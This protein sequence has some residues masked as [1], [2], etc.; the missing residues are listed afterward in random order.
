M[1]FALEA[2]VL[3]EVARQWIRKAAVAPE[4]FAGDWPCRPHQGLRGLEVEL[5]EPGDTGSAKPVARLR[6]LLAA[7][8]V[9]RHPQGRAA[10]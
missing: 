10:G 3:P 8:L 1:A 2:G 6:E 5:D 7:A 4:G 9:A